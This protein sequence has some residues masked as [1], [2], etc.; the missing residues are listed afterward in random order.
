MPQTVNNYVETHDIGKVIANQ[1]E[2]LELYSLDIAKYA[3][4]NDKKDQS[5]I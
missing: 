4:G 2:I 5:Y 3:V 1:K